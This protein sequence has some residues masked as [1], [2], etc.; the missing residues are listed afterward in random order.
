MNILL[1]Y[2]NVTTGHHLSHSIE[3]SNTGERNTVKTAS[4]VIPSIT[5]LAG[6]LKTKR[7]VCCSEINIFRKTTTFDRFLI[8]N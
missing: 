3:E 5:W 4:L 8:T 6:P 2:F 1:V 7:L